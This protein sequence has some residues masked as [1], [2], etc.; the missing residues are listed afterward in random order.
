MKSGDR[1]P[2]LRLTGLSGEDL[3]LSSF[4]GAPVVLT[5]LRYIG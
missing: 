3:T 5:F 4:R 1:A 2:E